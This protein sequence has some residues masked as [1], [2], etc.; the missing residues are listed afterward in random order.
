M[1]RTEVQLALS[2]VKEEARVGHHR[3]EKPFGDLPLKHCVLG[4]ETVPI[5]LPELDPLNR[6]FPRNRGAR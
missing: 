3:E 5:Y 6:R 1:V 2:T 4:T